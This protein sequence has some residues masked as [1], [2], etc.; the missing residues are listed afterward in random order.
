MK[1]A[2]WFCALLMRYAD[3]LKLFRGSAR[4]PGF[5]QELGRLLNELQEHQITPVKLRDHATR[6][7]L[8]RE[9]RAKLQDLA[10]LSEKYVDWLR[11]H[12]LQDGNH[13]LDF[14]TD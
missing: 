8:H 10:L 9:L 3:E 12:E 4:R 5:A 1:V 14:A 7:D 2:S 6:Q 11:D 13:L